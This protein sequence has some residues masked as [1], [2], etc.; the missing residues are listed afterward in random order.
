MK[1]QETPFTDIFRVASRGANVDLATL[2]PLS[3][4]INDPIRNEGCVTFTPDGKTIVFAKGNTER[5]KGGVDVDLYISRN[6][7]DVWSEP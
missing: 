2:Q 1:L 6:R 5:K 4:G 3:S 7:N